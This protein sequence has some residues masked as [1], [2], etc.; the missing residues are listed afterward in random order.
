LSGREA[1][2]VVEGTTSKIVSALD[3]LSEGEAAREVIGSIRECALRLAASNSL[4][5]S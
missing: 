5:P 2:D 1:V 4:S 3:D